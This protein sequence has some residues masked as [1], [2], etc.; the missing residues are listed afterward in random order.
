[1]DDKL[2]CFDVEAYSVIWSTEGVNVRNGR[3]V[4]WSQVIRKSIAKIPDGE[5]T[6]ELKIDT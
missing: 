3:W 5:I 4:I 6:E 2:E 1:M